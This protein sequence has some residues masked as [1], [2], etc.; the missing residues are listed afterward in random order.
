VVLPGDIDDPALPSGGNTYDRR[1]CDGLGDAG[2]SVRPVRA[3]GRWPHPTS[4][5]LERLA[6]LLAGMPG[7]A[8]VL[9]DGLV[10]CAAPEVVVPQARR[11]QLVVLV[12]L[13]LADE[14][15][16]DP[17]TARALDARERRT[18]RAAAAVVA[19]SSS[20]AHRLAARHR[21]AADRVRVALPG[22]DP[23]PVSLGTPG[24]R[25]LLCV[26][27][28]TP[29]KGQ[30][31][32]VE[33]L[34]QLS[35]LRWTCVCAGPLDRDRGFVD[36]VR[37]QLVDARLRDRVRFVGPRDDAQ[38][39]RLYARA[40]LLVLPSRA[41]PYGMVI[42]EALARGLPVLASA[43]DGIPQALGRG[44]DGEL[45]GMLV[46]PGRPD[47]LAEAVRDWL[48]EPDLRD[49]LRAAARRRRDGL[50]GWERTTSAL[51]AVL[52]EVGSRSECH[53]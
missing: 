50:R 36:R 8:T 6:G 51:A 30:D 19:T 33:A 46:P 18:L 5:D 23:A 26:A 10:A 40:D 1:V 17:A 27:S 15:G 39:A 44:P 41:E 16:L 2:W 42:T 35:D 20:V 13:P 3:P 28:V 48:V 34:S 47:V 32:L 49:R 24:G 31:V 43:V 9:L 25:H 21:L 12:H 53:A 29:R 45:P 11:L 38:V 14:T 7:G 52:E 22:V 37:G 4:G